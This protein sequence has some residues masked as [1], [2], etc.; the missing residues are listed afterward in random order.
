ML[1][2]FLKSQILSDVLEC[3]QKFSNVVRCS[4]MLSDVR[5]CSHTFIPS[6]KKKTSVC[7]LALL[8]PVLC[9]LFFFFILFYYFIGLALN[10]DLII[11]EMGSQAREC[12]WCV[13]L[14]VFPFLI[15]SY[16]ISSFIFHFLCV[17]PFVLLF[18]LSSFFFNISYS[19]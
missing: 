11:Y 10:L 4:R 15:F 2:G 1:S 3:C 17:L 18:C 5:E 7:F 19:H 14:F 16:F 9:N 8:V 6:P 12:V 13:Y